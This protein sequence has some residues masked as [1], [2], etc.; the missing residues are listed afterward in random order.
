MY[1][2]QFLHLSIS[3]NNY[4]RIQPVFWWCKSQSWVTLLRKLPNFLDNINHQLEQCPSSIG[5]ALISAR[6]KSWGIH[7]F[8]FI[9]PTIIETRGFPKSVQ[10]WAYEAQTPNFVFFRRLGITSISNNNLVC[11]SRN[12]I[13]APY[14]S[15]AQNGCIRMQKLS[16]GNLT[17][18]ELRPN[19]C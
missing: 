2:E 1:L 14:L 8:L 4:I 5:A 19:K 7:S 13:R 6:I 11:G 9:M 15:S 10:L 18:G 16:K 3:S 12:C 17:W